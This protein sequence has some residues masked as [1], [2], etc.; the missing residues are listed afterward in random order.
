MLTERPEDLCRIVH[1]LFRHDLVDVV[2]HEGCVENECPEL[3][4]EEE[5]GRQEGVCNHL[6]ED[7]LCGKG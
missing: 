2:G 6:W 7:E 1:V 5:A 4:R 3:E